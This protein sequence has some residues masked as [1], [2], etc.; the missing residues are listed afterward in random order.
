MVNGTCHMCCV[1]CSADLYDIKEN[2]T[3]IN[4]MRCACLIIQL[5]CKLEHR[6]GMHFCLSLIFFG[7]IRHCVS[8]ILICNLFWE[9]RKGCHTR[10]MQHVFMTLVEFI[11]ESAKI[12]KSLKGS[13]ETLAVKTFMWSSTELQV[14]AF[15]VT[16]F[17]YQWLGDIHKVF[18]TRWV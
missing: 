8:V 9:K 2:N 10:K 12:C 16:F 4:Y 15:G 5:I 6:I 7:V 14:Q 17:R 1:L 3:K 11:V 13:R 18:Q